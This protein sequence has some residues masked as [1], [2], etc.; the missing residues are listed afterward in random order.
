MDNLQET[1]KLESPA[2][3]GEKQEVGRN[4]N[5]TFMKG[6]SGN[7]EG[8][9]AGTTNFKTDFVRAIKKVA[10]VDDID[11]EEAVMVLIQTAYAM[12]KAGHFQFYKDL[13]DR[14]YGKT[15]EKIEYS[16]KMTLVQL[17]QELEAE[18]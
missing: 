3:A 2:N 17:V 7:P 9:K 1:R 13:V 4:Q 11:G 5:G 14:I 6:F 12:A 8:R 10:G 18:S 15:T 16:E